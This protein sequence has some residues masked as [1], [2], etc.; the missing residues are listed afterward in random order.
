MY[1]MYVMSVVHACNEIIAGLHEKNQSRP[2]EKSDGSDFF[3]E[4]LR[5]IHQKALILEDISISVYTIGDYS[6]IE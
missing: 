1:V 3:I 4:R 5:Q 2:F 6:Y